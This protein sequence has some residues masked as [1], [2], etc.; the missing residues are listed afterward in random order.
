M[1]HYKP[2]FMPKVL[3][4]SYYIEQAHT[5]RVWV[6]NLELIQTKLLKISNMT[7]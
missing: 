6:D 7:L 4:V 3:I 1:Y 5:N 2:K